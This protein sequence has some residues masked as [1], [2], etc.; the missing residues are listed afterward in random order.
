MKSLVKH[1]MLIQRIVYNALSGFFVAA[2]SWR[3]FRVSRLG[4]VFLAK[5]FCLFKFHPP[6]LRPDVQFTRAPWLSTVQDRSIN[7]YVSRDPRQRSNWIPR[8]ISKILYGSQ[9]LWSDTP[10]DIH[11]HAQWRPD[12]TVESVF[13]VHQYNSTS[14]HTLQRLALCNYITFYILLNYII[15]TNNK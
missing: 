15:L 7:L 5:Y 13:A 12:D 14:V 1:N 2:S 3:N 6:V 10:F 11:K 9:F 8:R 4:L